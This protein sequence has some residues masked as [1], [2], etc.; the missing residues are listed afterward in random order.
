ME[1][2][3]KD[4]CYDRVLSRKSNTLVHHKE[5]FSGNKNYNKQ[6]QNQVT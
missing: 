4:S 6:D 3:C 5:T 2:I 1:F